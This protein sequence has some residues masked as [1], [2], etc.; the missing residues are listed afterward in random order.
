MGAVYESKVS[1]RPR[2]CRQNCES[3]LAARLLVMWIQEP[4]GVRRKMY[5]I[6][7]G[8]E[9]GGGPMYINQLICKDPPPLST[10]LPALTPNES[11]LAAR[12]LSTQPWG[13]KKDVQRKGIG[14]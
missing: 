12:L 9:V 8:E 14:G 1:P 2:C 10:P 7:D 13:G 4:I 3:G 6:G 5:R 11:G